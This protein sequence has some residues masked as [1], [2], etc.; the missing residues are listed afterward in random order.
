MTKP[1]LGHLRVHAGQ[2]ELRCVAVA[3]ARLLAWRSNEKG[4]AVLPRRWVVK[5]TFSCL[6]PNRP[7]AKDFESLAESLAA[8]V[9][10]GSIQFAPRRLAR[11]HPVASD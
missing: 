2:Q 3:K 8:F 4:F 10:L 5:R 1:F 6:G 11:T 7:L 9:S